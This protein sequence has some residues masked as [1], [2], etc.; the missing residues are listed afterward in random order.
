MSA[1]TLNIRGKLVDLRTPAVMGILNITPDSF[2]TGSRL[3]AETEILKQ[4][5]KMLTE[6]AMFLDIG[7]Y[8]SRPGATDIPVEEELKRVITA[9]KVINKEFPEAFMSVD[10]FRA[11][12]ARHAVQEGASIINDISAGELDPSMFDTVAR[13]NVPYIAMHMRGTPQTMKELTHYENVVR[14]LMDY[15]I[16]KI[17]R[18]KALG[19]NDVVID[20]GLGF[21]KTVEQNFEVLAQLN[22]FTHLDK[23]VLAGL[24][25]KSMIWKT[26]GVTAADSLNGTTALNMTALMKGASILRV[27]DVKEAIEVVKLASQLY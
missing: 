11:E 24:S 23:P 16:D 2:Y 6:G 13:L 17:N 20:P 18:L 14:E 22:H 1:R 3:T 27:H 5:G 12:V 9:V 15:F 25:R 19:V 21:A 8:S 7:G 4:A 10:T 26:L